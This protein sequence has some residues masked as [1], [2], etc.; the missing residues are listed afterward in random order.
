MIFFL[1]I[2]ELYNLDEEEIMSNNENPIR[3]EIDEEQLGFECLETD[4]IESNTDA[5]SI[6]FSNIIQISNQNNLEDENDSDG[7]ADPIDQASLDET[8][9][10]LFD[11][12][13]GKPISTL[14]INLGTDDLPRYQCA[15]HKLDIAVKTAI[16]M[17][18]E[19][20]KIVQ[21]LNKSNNHFKR[22][23][24]LSKIFRNKK[25]RLRVQGK[26]RWSLVYLILESTKRALDKKAFD[27]SDDEKRCPINV[28]KIETYLQILKPLY[29]LNISLQSNYSTIGDV[30]P[31]K[32]IKSI[33]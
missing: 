12:N 25:C 6:T 16:K 26:Q 19:F 32:Y 22:V 1:K 24:K 2:L 10:E 11:Q 33:L 7:Q 20:T 21:T 23:C 3:D 9:Q 30:L 17:H 31:G 18:P 27:Q 14:N 28:E 8:E 5:N 15:D 4:I 13:L 29:L